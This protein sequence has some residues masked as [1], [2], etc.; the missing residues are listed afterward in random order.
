MPYIVSAVFAFKDVDVEN[1]TPDLLLFGN[2]SFGFG[3]IF[4]C[5][6]SLDELGTGPCGRSAQVASTTSTNSIQVSLSRAT[7]RSRGT[8]HVAPGLSPSKTFD[9]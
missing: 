9:S 5:F 6:D 2:E 3:G 8:Q 7:K 1:H 4:L